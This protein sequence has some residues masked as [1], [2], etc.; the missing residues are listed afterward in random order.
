M[1]SYK[2]QFQ[3]ILGNLILLYKNFFHWNISK[4][5]V[6]LYANILGFLVSSPFIGGIVY[7]YFTI[8]NQLGLASSPEQFILSNVGAIIITAL[9]MLCIVTIFICTYTYG[10]FLMMNVY[11]SY[12]EGEKLA[13]TKN[14]YFSRKYFSAYMGV[15]GWISLYML[16]P[17]LTGV[18]LV[19]PLG[20]L[21]KTV[22]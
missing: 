10:N 12:L 3:Q 6:F 4:V 7:Q 11:K 17:L 14:L 1:S 15:L 5:C 13:Y 21:A 18:V 20:F 8:Y 16:A 22:S 19:F 2:S 9:L